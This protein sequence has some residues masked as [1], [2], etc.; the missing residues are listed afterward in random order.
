MVRVSDF[1]AFGALMLTAG[2]QEGHLN[3]KKRHLAQQQQQ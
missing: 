1:V 2:C 3:H